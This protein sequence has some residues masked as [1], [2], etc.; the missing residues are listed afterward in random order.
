MEEMCEY[1]MMLFGFCNC[2]NARDLIGLF[3]RDEMYLTLNLPRYWG[4]GV[5]LRIKNGFPP[6]VIPF[7]NSKQLYLTL[8][9][10]TCNFWE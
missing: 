5:S 10:A 4:V 9:T 7:N 3:G 6:A 2:W 8:D 1:K